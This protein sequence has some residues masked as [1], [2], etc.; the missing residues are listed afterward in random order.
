M[1]YSHSHL[2]STGEPHVGSTLTPGVAGY[3]STR[4]IP[5]PASVN[6]NSMEVNTDVM[7]GIIR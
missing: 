4:S 7:T 6:T 5:R 2:H 1:E 3:L